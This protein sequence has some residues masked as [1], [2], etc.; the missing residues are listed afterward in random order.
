MVV[1]NSVLVAIESIACCAI[2]YLHHQFELLEGPI[3][4]LAQKLSAAARLGFRLFRK[5]FS[6][7]KKFVGPADILSA[8]R[9][10]LDS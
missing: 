5:H 6:F 10:V 3:S 2:R 7:V 4:R 8:A 9:I 1:R